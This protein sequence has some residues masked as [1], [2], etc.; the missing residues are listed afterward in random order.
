MP[1]YV[2]AAIVGVIV[3]AW[4]VSEVIIGVINH[5][6]TKR[7]LEGEIRAGVELLSA[8]DYKMEIVVE[9]DRWC[10][11]RLQRELRMEATDA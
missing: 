11:R 2:P 6:R 4:I 7:W 8:N 9:R 5:R 1:L 3:L 10:D